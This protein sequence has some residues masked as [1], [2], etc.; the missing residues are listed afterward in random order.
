MYIDLMTIQKSSR[1]LFTYCS[2]SACDD[3]RETKVEGYFRNYCL[4]A[5]LHGWAI[6]VK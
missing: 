4:E 6:A 3:S 2:F 5:L 1:G